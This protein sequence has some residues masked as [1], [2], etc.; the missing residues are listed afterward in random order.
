MLSRN[1]KNQDEEVHHDVRHNSEP[2]LVKTIDAFLAS[3]EKRAY[4]MAYIATS[5]KEDA[6]DIV[7]DAMITLVNKYSQRGYT[8][9]PPLFYRIVQNT[10]R[11][12]YRRQSVRNKFRQWF[13]SSESSDNDMEQDWESQVM[14]HAVN[15]RDNPTVDQHQNDNAMQH[16]MNELN[17]LPL[18][19]Q[20]AFLLRCWEGLD[21]KQTAEAMNITEGSVKTHY[22]RATHALREQLGDHYEK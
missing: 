14:P 13:S 20:Q 5:N 11:D 22:S 18:R 2:I 19:Q 8:E 15:V 3:V 4:R 1:E 6:L 12:W 17:Q 21:T 16:L 10:I 7:Q 9:W